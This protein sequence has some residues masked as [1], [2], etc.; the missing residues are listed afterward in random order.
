MNQYI[1]QTVSKNGAISLVFLFQ[2]DAARDQD[3]AH[4]IHWLAVIGNIRTSAEEKI[5]DLNDDGDPHFTP[6]ITV[7]RDRQHIAYTPAG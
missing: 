1:P 5:A 3:P 7:S 6:S 2:P 4:I